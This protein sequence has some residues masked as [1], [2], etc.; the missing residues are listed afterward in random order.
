LQQHI[1]QKWNE[2]LFAE[3]AL[4]YQHGRLGFDPAEGWYDG[5]L[6][7][8]DHYVI[9]MARN[10]KECGVFGVSSD[11]YLNYVEENRREWQR[12]GKEVVETYVA[13]YCK[14]PEED[15]GGGGVEGGGKSSNGDSKDAGAATDATAAV[16]DGGDGAPTTGGRAQRRGSMK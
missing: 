16:A 2:R 3:M 14:K 11:E 5:E 8:L 9:P 10:L 6:G 12:K 13:K 4:A 7:F 15:G 1:Y